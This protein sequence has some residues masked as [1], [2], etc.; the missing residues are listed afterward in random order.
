MKTNRD[1]VVKTLLNAD[2]Y[3]AFEAKCESEDVPQ[4]KAL[5]D[6]AKSWIANRQRNGRRGQG[7]TE[8]PAFGH[9]LAMLLPPRANSNRGM[10]MRL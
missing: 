4:S 2:E 8:R 7:R 1:I 6:L 9:N 3:L 10:H 5:R